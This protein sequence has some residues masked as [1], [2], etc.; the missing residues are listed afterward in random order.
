MIDL[1]K[2]NIITKV[3]Q[4]SRLGVSALAIVAISGAFGPITLPLSIVIGAV[5]GV[6]V[7][8]KTIENVNAR[9]TSNGK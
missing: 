9:K 4:S 3:L 7:V 8:A 2:E 1:L 6:Y 5:S